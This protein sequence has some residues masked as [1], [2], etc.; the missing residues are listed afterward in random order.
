METQTGIQN[1]GEYFFAQLKHLSTKSN[2]Y[3]DNFTNFPRSRPIVKKPGTHIRLSGEVVTP[4]HRFKG[5]QL[6]KGGDNRDPIE[7]YLNEPEVRKAQ[8]EMM[9]RPRPPT[10]GGGDVNG[11]S[12]GGGDSNAQRFIYEDTVSQQPEKKQEEDIEKIVQPPAELA[13]GT[14]APQQTQS[15]SPFKF[16]VENYDQKPGEKK[17]SLPKFG[18]RRPSVTDDYSAV[19]S[20]T[21]VIEGN[22]DY[23][24]YTMDYNRQQQKNTNNSKDSYQEAVEKRSREMMRQNSTQRADYRSSSTSEERT[25]AGPNTT[26]Q[27]ESFTT[28][29]D[30]RESSEE[31][32]QVLENTGPAAYDSTTSTNDESFKV[33]DNREAVSRHFI[34]RDSSESSDHVRDSSRH[35]HYSRSTSQQ[36]PPRIGH[37]MWQS[38]ETQQ[39]DTNAN[40]RAMGYDQK[41]LDNNN[42][43]SLVG[44][45]PMKPTGWMKPE[46]YDLKY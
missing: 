26:F 31:P 40:K 36:T 22:P 38:K 33:L 8:M 6:A 29:S 14:G 24:R 23:V 30:P 20:R 11:G 42:A 41:V 21:N 13:T 35:R 25:R 27:K 2:F 44:D 7:K 18:R 17:E 15:R 34:N 45:R 46:W 39:Y 1:I 10:R 9:V 37:T 5:Y 12:G 28:S 32:F 19:R 43:F 4:P 16:V 3:R